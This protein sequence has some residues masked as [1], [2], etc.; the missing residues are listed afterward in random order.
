VICAAGFRFLGEEIDEAFTYAAL[1]KAKTLGR[2]IGSVAWLG[3]WRQ[4]QLK[5]FYQASAAQGRKL[6]R[7]LRTCHRNSRISAFSKL[8]P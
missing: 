3:R 6:F 7:G 8:A 2:P 4:K 1:R 5:H